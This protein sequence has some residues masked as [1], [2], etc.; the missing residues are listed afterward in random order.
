L[1]TVDSNC[2]LLTNMTILNVNNEYNIIRVKIDLR[3]V[4]VTGQ[5]TGGGGHIL[6]IKIPSPNPSLRLFTFLF[7]VL[8]YVPYGLW[9]IKYV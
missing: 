1:L 5:K 4:D 7:D 6:S 8:C 3:N 2:L 9:P